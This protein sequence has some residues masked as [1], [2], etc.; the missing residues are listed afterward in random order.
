MLEVVEQVRRDDA[1]LVFDELSGG[2]ST[3]NIC[4]DVLT[5]SENDLDL[6]RD[7]KNTI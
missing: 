1:A 5:R 6:G 2:G 3:G 7:T 4:V